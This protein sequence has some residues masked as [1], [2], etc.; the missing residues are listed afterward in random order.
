MA[1]NNTIS[2]SCSFQCSR[3]SKCCE[4]VEYHAKKG[5]FPA[6]FFSVSGERTGDRSFESLIKDR[7]K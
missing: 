1:C 4:C 6:C 3:H 5:E 2:C 7:N